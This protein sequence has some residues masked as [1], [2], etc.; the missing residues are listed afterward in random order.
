[1]FVAVLQ[2]LYS[3]FLEVSL[4]FDCLLNE[5]YSLKEREREREAGGSMV[6]VMLEFEGRS[7]LAEV[8]C[9]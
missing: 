4:Y 6:V 2:Y 1:V 5:A 8:L 9:L 3:S 7:M